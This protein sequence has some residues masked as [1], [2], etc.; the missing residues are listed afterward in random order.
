M[1]GRRSARISAAALVIAGVMG[2][3]AALQSDKGRVEIRADE[4]AGINRTRPTLA[5]AAT[6]RPITTTPAPSPAPTTATAAPTTG[7]SATTSTSRLQ[8]APA[9]ASTTTSPTAAAIVPAKA[10][11][12]V[13]RAH[14]GT[15]TVEARLDPPHPRPGEVVRLVA[16][17]TDTSGGQFGAAMNWGDRRQF[18]SPGGAMPLCAADPNRASAPEPE[19]ERPPEPT[20]HSYDFDHIYRRDG[21]YQIGLV[22]RSDH[23]GCSDDNRPG[24]SLVISETVVVGPPSLQPSNGPRQPEASVQAEAGYEDPTTLRFL[25]GGHDRDGYITRLTLDLGDGTPPR[26]E[27]RPLH[28]CDDDPA[29]W[30]N[31]SAGGPFE[32]RY[33][34]P[35][36]YTVV[37]TVAS[38]GCDGT[39][40]QTASKT[41]EVDY[42]PR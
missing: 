25:Y 33:Q 20:A 3:V 27:D 7:T 17:A 12:V 31:S 37:V 4:P 1:T 41:I 40:V 32:H 6:T 11:P 5:V 36:R 22:V 26:A 15:L 8:P 39:A 14:N 10:E 24:S 19:A 35:G 23:F 16:H 9:P 28:W 42:P 29:Y 13:W 34:A 38:S 30:P 21:S 18:V 2:S